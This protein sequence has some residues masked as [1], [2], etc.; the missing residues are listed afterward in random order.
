[1]NATDFISRTEYD[2]LKRKAD[3]SEVFSFKKELR[4][5]NNWYSIDIG[6]RFHISWERENNEQVYDTFSG[7]D[8]NYKR[9][10]GEMQRGGGGG[11]ATSI[12]KSYDECKRQINSN[13]KHMPDYDELEQITLF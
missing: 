11:P 1:M 3:N 4:V 12:L 6:G 10:D 13:L 7:Y 2:E 9:K 5:N 8:Y